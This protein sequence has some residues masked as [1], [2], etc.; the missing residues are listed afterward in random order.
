MDR[1]RVTP[2]EPEALDEA[3]VLTRLGPGE[4]DAERWRI[5]L[6][7]TLARVAHGGVLVGRRPTGRVCGL[8]KYR[9]AQDDEACRGLEIERLIAFDLMRP[10]EVA[11][12]MV[13]EAIR[14]AR[15]EGCDTLHLVRPLVPED[16]AATLVLAAG[17]GDL[18][19]V[20]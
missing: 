20:F 15:L 3:L 8:L 14:L 16:A 13:A 17:I 7:D 10:R 2:L 5:D 4:Q 6:T 11:D 19:S 18:H 9:I 1:V 12:A